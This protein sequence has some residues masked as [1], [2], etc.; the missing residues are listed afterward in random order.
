MPDKG[1][2]KF[3]KPFKGEFSVFYGENH[4]KITDYPLCP[5][6]A[7]AVKDGYPSRQICFTSFNR[8][9]ADMTLNGATA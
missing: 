8:M 2:V 7:D 6:I 5:V 9:E 3:E 4:S 1:I